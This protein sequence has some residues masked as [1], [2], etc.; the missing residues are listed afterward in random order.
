MT[1]NDN[2]SGQP[3]AGASNDDK[4][5]FE[6]PAPTTFADIVQLIS[7]TYHATSNRQ[8]KTDEQI[9]ALNDK[10]NRPMRQLSSIS[11]PTFDASDRDIFHPRQTPTRT[12]KLPA[13]TPQMKTP[14]A[15]IPSP[16]PQTF[17]PVSQSRNLVHLPRPRA[18]IDADRHSTRAL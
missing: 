5:P 9:A 11:S 8:G 17:T 13:P 12:P 18:V 4:P 7:E 1:D 16:F 14:I 6:I 10:I 15:Q 2:T 3:P